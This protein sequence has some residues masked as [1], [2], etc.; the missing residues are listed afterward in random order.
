MRRVEAMAVGVLAGISA[1]SSEYS[2]AEEFAQQAERIAPDDPGVLTTTW[3]ETRV[4]AAIFGNDLPRALD[5]VARGIA[6]ARTGRLTA[7]I[8][9]WGYWPLLRT[10]SGDD[11]AEAIA[12][13]MEAGAEVAFWNRSCLAYAQALLAGRDGRLDLAEIF[14]ERGRRLFARSAPWWNH[15][16]HRL[17][18]ADAL[19]AGWGEPVSWLRDAIGDL[20]AAG[21]DRLASACRGVLRQAGERVPRTGRGNASVPRQLRSLGIT[22]REMDVFLL[23]AQGISNAEIA[24]RL[25]ISRKTVETHICSLV[26]KTGQNGRRELVAH[27]ARY[28]PPELLAPRQA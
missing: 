23:V 27:A 14:A 13:A 25:F 7:P 26:T 24:T 4:T 22:S 8:L 17:V 16:M 18:A 12:E 1:T 15:M 5:A 19:R 6:F 11:G 9:V 2:R 21:L 28:V 3:G 20:E 10:I